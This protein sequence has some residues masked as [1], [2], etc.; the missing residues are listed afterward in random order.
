MIDSVW[1]PLLG[2][3]LLGSGL[4]TALGLVPRVT[5]PTDLGQGAGLDVAGGVGWAVAHAAEAVLL[6]PQD[7]GWILWF[8]L[9]VRPVGVLPLGPARLASAGVG[10]EG[11]RLEFGNW[12]AGQGNHCGAG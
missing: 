2:L 7:F 6:D 4:R 8:P 3:L 5:V 10:G 1:F 12:F 11:L 9:S